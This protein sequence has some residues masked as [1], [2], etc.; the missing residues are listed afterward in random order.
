LTEL[1]VHPEISRLQAQLEQFREELAKL[2]AERE[3]LKKTVLPNIAAM[4]Q[5]ELGTLEYQ[6]F[7]LQVEIKR[8]RRTLQLIQ[9]AVNRNEPISR[10]A[11]EAQ[12]S[13]EFS[14][15]EQQMQARLRKIN[16]ARQH[17][18]ELMSAEDSEKCQR[19]YRQLVKRLHPDLHP[20]QP[21]GHRAIWLQV[22]GAYEQ[23]DLAELETL[24]LLVQQSGEDAPA[25]PSVQ[26]QLQRQIEFIQGRITVLLREIAGIK[27]SDTYRLGEQLDDPEW[28]AKQRERL[29]ASIEQLHA[30]RKQLETLVGEMLEGGAWA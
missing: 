30:Q 4:H 27:E 15:W 20:E 7:G 3:H 9:A 11:I 17:L 12:L 26:E 19:L 6:E 8:L 22:M 1:I 29:E 14:Q 18:N 10:T 23:G 28:L 24:W 25:M 16:Q 13:R 5:L 21:E 2:L